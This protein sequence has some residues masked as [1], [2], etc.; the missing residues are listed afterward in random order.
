MFSNKLKKIS[1]INLMW[2]LPLL[3]FLHNLEEVMTM[4]SFWRSN[5]WI[6][7]LPFYTFMQSTDLQFLV[8]VAILTLIVVLI[9]YLA[10]KNPSKGKSM[11]LFIL[12][13]LLILV[14]AIIHLIQAL[15]FRS[16]VPGLITGLL[17]IVPYS[18][19]L[20]HRIFQEELISKIRFILM[21][22]LGL[23]LQIPIII[24]T[25][26]IGKLLIPT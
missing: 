12:V 5:P 15:I 2:I 7:S 22:F 10:S 8:S 3:A 18:L 6:Q 1:L 19:I 14:N 25:L 13:L 24:T 23:I 16:Y 17:L 21:L 4:G 9:T 26:G 11:N 20:F